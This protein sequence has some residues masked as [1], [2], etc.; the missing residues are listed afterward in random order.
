MRGG[1]ITGVRLEAGEVDP[2]RPARPDR[3]AR[4]PRSASRSG[5]A[6]T[7]RA[8]SSSATT[9]H[10]RGPPRLRDR[11]LRAAARGR[12]G[13]HRAGLG[14]GPAP[15]HPAHRASTAASEPALP[16]VGTDVV[17]VKGAGL[18]VVTMG[19]C[20]V[21]AR[22]GRARPAR[23]A[24]RPRRRP[25]HRGRR[26]RRARRSV[27]PASARGRSPRTSSRPT[28]AAPR[29]RC[30]PAQLLLRP[31]A[32]LR[33]TGRLAGRDAR[34]CRDLPVQRRHQGGHRRLLAARRPQRRGRRRRDP[35]DHRLR[36]L[37][38]RRVR[39]RRLAQADRPG[40]AGA[41][42]RAGSGTLRAP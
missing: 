20:G 32:G 22:R 39:H 36:R 11:R 8:A 25:A 24:Q 21:P 28:R 16:S 14:P 41:G 4:W 26:R 33:G 15:R 5:R 10:A 30:R 3:R 17:K 37:Q 2:R 18:D 34:P 42:A 7:W 23:P 27:R 35:C 6:W 31:V 40:P 13:A 12:L 38:G 1:R 9:C 19:V 29:R